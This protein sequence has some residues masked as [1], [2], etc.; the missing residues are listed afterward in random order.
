LANHKKMLDDSTRLA[1]ATKELVGNTSRSS[2]NP[3]GTLARMG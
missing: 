2:L 1:G 3:S